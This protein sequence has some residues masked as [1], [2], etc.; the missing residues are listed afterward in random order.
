MAKYSESVYS[1][2][3]QELR[4]RKLEAEAETKRRKA[5]LFAQDPDVAAISKQL[6]GTANEYLKIILN[7]G[8]ELHD[9]IEKL[10]KKSTE[11]SSK[12]GSK[13]QAL[14]GDR[15]YFKT[16]Y[17]CRVCED[18]GYK[19]GLRC[20]CF[21]AL[22]KQYAAEEMAENCGI[23]LND[24]ADFKL[25]YYSDAA[26]ENVS[27]RARMKKTY[28]YCR[29]YSEGFSQNSPSLLFIGKTGLGKTFLSSCIAKEVMEK[30]MSVAIG[31][32]A[33]FLRKVEDEHFGRAA[34]NTLDTLIGCDLLI[35]DDL[36]SE[37]QSQFTE[38]AL[39]EIIN[40]RLNAQ[41]PTII[42]T[43]Q[44]ISELNMN[45]NERLVSR[46]TGSYLPFIFVGKD[47][48]PMIRKF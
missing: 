24:F 33:T 13:L 34:G 41:R 43:N 38:S 19:D 29:K 18:S 47:I 11:L 16:A 15:D 37:F 45:Y 14:T 10:R 5:E 23:K 21:E 31:Q 3:G 27:P 44:S 25:D 8:T 17:S 9:N 22:L 48:R 39:Y 32:L 4:R 42:S 30:G 26:D 6:E 28:D 36:G 40:A 35:L 20:K 2:A 7:G 46:I 12:L 1:R